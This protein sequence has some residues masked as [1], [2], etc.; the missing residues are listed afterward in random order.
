[1]VDAGPS[2]T[3]IAMILF[4]IIGCILVVFLGY[5]VRSAYD[6]RI[7]LKAQLDRGLRAVEEDSG[8]KAR[9]LRQELGGEIERTRA[10]LAEESRRR[11]TEAQAAMDKRQSEFESSVRQD[12]IQTSVTLDLMRDQLAELG[13]RIDEIERELV[14]GDS[15]DMDPAVATATPVP[16]PQPTRPA[17]PSAAPQ[18]PSQPGR[19]TSGG[20]TSF[21][22]SRTTASTGAMAVAVK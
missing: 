8:K 18:I 3:T 14:V 9:S 6:M 4:V 5:L 1:M 17:T 10:A 11:L 2:W 12:R 22:T 16:A 20:S 21:T 13:R 7:G 15:M 19:A